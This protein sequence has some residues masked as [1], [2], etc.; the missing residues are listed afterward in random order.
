MTLCEQYWW[1]FL[2]RARSL[3]PKIITMIV[4]VNKSHP[5][6]STAKIAMMVKNQ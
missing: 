5:V 3:K 4:P 2:A 1:M 6:R